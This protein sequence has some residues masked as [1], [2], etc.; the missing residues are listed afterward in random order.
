[1]KLAEYLGRPAAALLEAEPFCAWGVRRTVDGGQPSTEVRYEL[2][3]DHVEL[4]CD[5]DESVR[6][7]FLRPGVDESLSEISFSSRREAVRERF[8][9]PE[10]S[11]EPHHDPILGDYGAWDRFDM[12]LAA[13]HFQ[14]RPDSDG[15]AMITLMRPDVVPSQGV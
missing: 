5:Q 4:L 9:V 13:I 3:G 8:G 2:E 1:M 14:Y 12:G 15:I 11:G 6:S 7:I 10:T